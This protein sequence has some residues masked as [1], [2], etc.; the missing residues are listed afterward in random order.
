[1]SKLLFQVET[2]Q[3]TLTIF[4]SFFGQNLLL[5]LLYVPTL[6]TKGCLKF[7]KIITFYQSVRWLIG[8]LF[9]KLIKDWR[10]TSLRSHTLDSAST[11][12]NGP[13]KMASTDFEGFPSSW[14]YFLSIIRKVSS[15]SPLIMFINNDFVLNLFNSKIW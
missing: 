3:W 2:N 8:I 13:E 7:A 6:N 14:Y 4:H 11:S 10:L 1:M 5:V 9:H 12:V 15:H